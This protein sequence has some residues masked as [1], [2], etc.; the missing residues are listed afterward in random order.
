MK[1]HSWTIFWGWLNVSKIGKGP[2]A[3]VPAK[4]NI[5]QEKGSE[6]VPRD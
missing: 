1:F 2:N 3:Y 4:D 5:E 6:W